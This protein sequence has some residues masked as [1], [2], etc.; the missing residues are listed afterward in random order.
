MIFICQKTVHK[1]LIKYFLV[2]DY[3][4]LKNTKRQKKLHAAYVFE[5]EQNLIEV[6]YFI[7]HGAPYPEQGLRRTFASSESSA[8]VNVYIAYVRHY[9]GCK[10][11]KTLYKQAINNYQN[12]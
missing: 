12:T 8:R 7:A 3:S 1:L 10:S 9:S 11:M 5:L 6:N 4:L 2:T